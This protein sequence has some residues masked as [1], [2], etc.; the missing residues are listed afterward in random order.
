MEILMKLSTRLVDGTP[1]VDTDGE[2][3]HLGLPQFRNELAS[4][5]EQGHR[6]IV[7]DMS[8]VCFMDSGGVSGVVYAMKRLATLNGAI[9]LAACNEIIL[10]KLEIGGLAKISPALRLAPSVEQAVRELQSV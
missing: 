5:I 4:L 10:R 7:V 3:D 1:V 2:M 9:T 8:D 6:R